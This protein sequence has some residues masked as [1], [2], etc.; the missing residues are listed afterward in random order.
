MPTLYIIFNNMSSLGRFFSKSS[1]RLF[2]MSINPFY[3]GIF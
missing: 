1:F 3:V 2:F